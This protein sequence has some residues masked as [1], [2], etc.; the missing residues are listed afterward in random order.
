MSENAANV[1]GATRHN[2]QR[3]GARLYEELIQRCART[4]SGADAYFGVQALLGVDKG[5]GDELVVAP[6]RETRETPAIDVEI[7]PAAAAL[8]VV[9]PTPNAF[10][11]SPRRPPHREPAT[12][13]PSAQRPRTRH[14]PAV[15]PPTR[16]Q[17][18]SAARA[19]SPAA[20]CA[21]TRRTA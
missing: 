19:H 7:R 3:A 9:V 11:L 15:P 10:S 17:K 20:R 18:S 5:G 8:L 2:A 21:A 13:R 1:K 12:P 6:K 16:R 14:P 4:S